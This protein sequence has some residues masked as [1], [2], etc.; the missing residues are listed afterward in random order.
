MT[1]NITQEW[2]V[3]TLFL[4]DP[5]HIF[6]Q[7]LWAALKDTVWRRRS[8]GQNYLMADADDTLQTTTTK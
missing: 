4:N 8:R 3:E 6:I 7:H 5:Y 2:L 1:Q